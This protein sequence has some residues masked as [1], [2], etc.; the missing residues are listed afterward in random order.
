MKVVTFFICC[1]LQ[2]SLWARTARPLRIQ[3]DV[4]YVQSR[5]SENKADESLEIPSF[6][7]TSLAA[8]MRGEWF[9]FPHWFYMGADVEYRSPI[10]TEGEAKFSFLRQTSMSALVL[11]SRPFHLSLVAEQ[12]YQKFDSDHEGLGYDSVNGVHFYPQ[13]DLSLKGGSRLYIRS[14]LYS[15][16][17]HHK[18]IQAGAELRFSGQEGP[19]PAHLYQE[20]FLL[21]FEYTKESLKFKKLDELEVETESFALS[22]SYS[23]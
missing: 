21:K 14:P 13:L 22:L 6:T 7:Q 2:F 8:K 19:Y 16:L 12:F 17:D 5:Y 23:F 11:N 15:N 3:T 1:L 18:L 20:S 9:V 10:S 4:S